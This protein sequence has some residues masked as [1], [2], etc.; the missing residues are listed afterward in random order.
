MLLIRPATIDDTALVS[1]DVPESE[2][3]YDPATSYS[4]GNIVRGNVTLTAHRRFESLVNSNVGNPLSDAAK[5]LEIG[6]TN[7]WAMFDTIV[8]TQTENADSIA[9]QL[10]T[11]G[12]VDSVA[13]LNVSAASLQVVM[14]DAIEGVVYDETIPL[15]SPSG[16]IDWYAY[17]FEPIVRLTDMVV[18]GMPPYAGAE[19]SVTLL[20]TGNTAM[21]GALV[22]GQSKDIG[23]AQYGATVGIRDFSRKEQNDFG[24][25]LVVERAF[26]KRASFNVWMPSGLTDQVQN[27]LA[28]YR[29][30]PIVYVGSE[31]Y[32]STLIFGFY[33]DFNVEL[34]GPN[35]SLCS[36]EIE[37]LT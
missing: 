35:H 31:A 20:D 37:G 14:T 10:T 24:D 13:V 33:R 19:V 8:G 26:S 12:R 17:F 3:V 7:R 11:P 29:A 2:G 22:F 23:D 16:V 28:S 36:I 34:A 6:P 21:C 30:T 9:V 5:W 15:V 4:I 32:G 1:S 27:L 18:T 25:F